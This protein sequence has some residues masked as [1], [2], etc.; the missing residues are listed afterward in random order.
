MSFNESSPIES[1]NATSSASSKTGVWEASRTSL[2]GLARAA[3]LYS[4][5]P[6][7]HQR[8]EEQPDSRQVLSLRRPASR[9]LIQPRAH[10]IGFY[11]FEFKLTRRT[12]CQEFAPGHPIRAS[13]IWIAHTRS[14]ELKEGLRGFGSG[15]LDHPPPL[16]VNTSFPAWINQKVMFLRD[17]DWA[18]VVKTSYFPPS[19]LSYSGGPLEREACERASQANQPSRQGFRTISRKPSAFHK[20]GVHGGRQSGH[21]S[22]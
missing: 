17:K 22:R 4:T 13:S 7:H 8:I 11:V 10:V 1:K 5:N 14:Q 2:G 21:Q 18:Q 12:K 19:S 9:M 6:S 3:G 15:A 16:R 20:T